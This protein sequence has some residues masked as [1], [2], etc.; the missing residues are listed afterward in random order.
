MEPD[1]IR[2]LAFP[3]ESKV[4]LCVMDGLGGLPGSRG[5]TELEEADTRH[6]DE[7]AAQGATGQTIPVGIGIT[8]GSGPGHLALFG[9]DP[10]RF[11]VGRGALEAT[12]IDFELGPHDVAARGNLCTVDAE[13]RIVDRRAGRVATEITTEIAEQLSTIDLPGVELIVR[14]VREHRFAF[15]LR[16]EGL[17]AEMSETDPQREG[18]APLLAEPTAAA[19]QAGADA[20]ARTASLVNDFVA[21]AR[22]RIGG[23]EQANALTLRG[24][25]TRPDLPQLPELWGLRAAAVAVYPMYRG[26]ARLVG[27]DVLDAGDSIET[28]IEA[29]RRHWDEYDFFFVHWKHTDSAGEDGDFTRKAHAI[30]DFD[31]A[32]PGILDLHPNVLVVTGDHSTPST[33][34][35]HSWHPVPLLIS[36][37]NVRTD[38]AHLFGERECARGGLGTIPAREVLP[39]AFAHAGRLTKYG[40]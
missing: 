27:M 22:R 40:A 7:L 14:P 8:P 31:D 1:L 16:G 3:A 24:W 33:M 15:V 32:L 23:R 37:D 19:A 30:R 34:A 28:Q 29:L 26:L 39:L 5:R 21:E 12:G 18:V 2:R 25:A 11:E 17:S 35:A 38:L 6:L 4:V 10:L 13:G 36:G 9:L 20:A